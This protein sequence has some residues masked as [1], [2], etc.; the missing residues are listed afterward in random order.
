MIKY[1]KK[2]SAVTSDLILLF[3]SDD[4]SEKEVRQITAQIS[5]ISVILTFAA[6]FELVR[7]KN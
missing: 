2:C 1:S 4:L 3:N 6:I 7:I 5:N